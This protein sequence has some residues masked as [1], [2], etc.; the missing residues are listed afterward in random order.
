[1][2]EEY[3]K[4][5]SGKL[6]LKGDG[7]E[8]RRKAKKKA[9]KEKKARKRKLNEEKDED[10]ELHGGWY[11]VS[12]CSCPFLGL[13]CFFTVI[14]WELFIREFAAVAPSDFAIV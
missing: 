6:K 8:E 9:K 7:S 10:E 13:F 12:Y 5:K 3:K 11:I 1:M 14:N 4:V 2:S